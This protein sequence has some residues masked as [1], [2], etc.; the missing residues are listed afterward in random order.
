MLIFAVAG[1]H[2]DEIVKQEKK[3]GKIYTIMGAP[4]YNPDLG[5]IV[6]AYGALADN[7]LKNDSRFTNMPYINLYSLALSYSTKGMYALVFDWDAPNYEK[8]LFRIRARL[9]Y[10][11]NPVESFYGIDNSS[12]KPLTAYDGQ[13]F[14]SFT[15]YNDYMKVIH[16]GATHAYYN[17]YTNET[18]YFHLQA[19]MP[20]LSPSLKIV[21]GIMGGYT[22][23]YDYTGEMVP[24]TEH[25]GSDET[26]DAL[27][28]ETLLHK[29]QSEGRLFGFSGGWLMTLRTGIAFDTRDNE[30]DPTKGLY[31]DIIYTASSEAFGADYSYSIG[32]ATIRAYMSPLA[33]AMTLAV[34]GSL[35]SKWGDVPFYSMPYIPT[36][37]RHINGIGGE[38]TLRGFKQSR[39]CAPVMVFGN[40]EARFRFTQFS[41][42]TTGVELQVVPFA[43]IGT[44]NNKISDI[45][46]GELKYS[47]GL[48]LRGII[49]QTF[50][51]S[52][53]CGFSEEN[54]A[55][56]Y[57]NF[58]IIF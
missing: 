43:D 27:M 42:G 49:E 6:A 17:Y 24:G 56:F 16:N 2:A 1:M 53:D 39:F 40:A 52:I 13:Q 14:S 11:N 4:S 19:D 26:N 21:F 46:S 20:V 31:S 38:G 58:G 28:Q 51:V 5:F 29:Y 47:Y 30:I 41:I 57:M 15:P 54:T 55:E 35:V 50:A 44:V 32:T 3:E 7:G 22:W 18:L 12:L 9:S 25:L 8:T 33:N 23:I 36:F 37:D 34:R 10:I 48:G 45:G